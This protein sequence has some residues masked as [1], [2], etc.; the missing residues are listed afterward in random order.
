M[1][2]M[3]LVNNSIYIKQFLYDVFAYQA[4]YRYVEICNTASM[5][6]DISTRMEVFFLKYFYS[7]NTVKNVVYIHFL[8]S[9]ER[10]KSRIK[11]KKYLNDDFF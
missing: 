8:F 10:K 6:K 2:Y 3:Q 7:I 11:R 9:S 5:L 1:T 4:I